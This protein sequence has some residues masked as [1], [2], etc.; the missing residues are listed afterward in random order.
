L[1]GLETTI[2]G[3][4]GISG[5]ECTSFVA[6]TFDPIF[7]A[8]YIS[9]MRTGKDMFGNGLGAISKTGAKFEDTAMRFMLDFSMEA[10]SIVSEK[11]TWYFLDAI[12][13]VTEEHATDNRRTRNR[14]SQCLDKWKHRACRHT[15]KKICGRIE[16]MVGLSHTG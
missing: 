16:G 9:I 2:C 8:N 4:F 14:D 13:Q 1:S 10:S 7:I 5:D 3:M 15:D 11:E 6:E 12:R